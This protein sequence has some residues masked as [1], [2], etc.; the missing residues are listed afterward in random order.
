MTDGVK[1]DL[2]IDFFF[3]QSFLVIKI[4]P[5]RETVLSD[6]EYDIFG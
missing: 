3:Y 2:W 5:T 4:E 1:I 6:L